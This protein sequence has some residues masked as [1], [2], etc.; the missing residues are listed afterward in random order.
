[1][2]S[3]GSGGVY[4]ISQRMTAALGWAA[5]N[6]VDDFVFDQ[7]AERYVQDKDMAARL[8]KANPEAFKN[9][10]GRLLETHARG[11]WNA[12]PNLI[13]QLRDIY[14]DADDIIEGVTVVQQ[15]GD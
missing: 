2:A 4:E 15:P 5:T 6:G 14:D 11:L 10:V 13:D 1:M 3:Q 9:V 12:D 8:Q 7:A